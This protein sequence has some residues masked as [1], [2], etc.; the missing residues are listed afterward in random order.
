M[1]GDRWTFLVVRGEDDPVRQYS[2]SL[3]TIRLLGGVAALSVLA[4]VASTAILLSDAATRV[5][6]HSLQ[7]RNQVLEEELSGFQARIGDLE[8]SLDR[9][10]SNDAHFRSLAGLE[11]IDPEVLEAGVG[12]PGLGSP[13][14]S[15][16]WPT[17][18]ATTN[19]IF[20]TGYDLSALERRARLLSE[21][22]EEATDSVLAHRNLL[23]STPSL[24]PTQGWLS[25]RFSQSRMHPVHNRPLPHE[26]VD[27]SAP[28]GTPIMAAAKG[29]VVRSGWVVGYGLTVEIDHGYGFQ[30]LYGHASKLIVQVGDEV[31]RGDVI[32]Q[33]GSTGITTA[34]NLH[35]EVKVNGVAQDPS[36]FILPDY[37]RN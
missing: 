18:P 20:A 6:A 32:A 4:I 31:L 23:E 3:R 35:Y 12:G 2:L 24:L 33:V 30:T 22:L 37:V 27:I 15:P 25:S 14:N 13:E 5:Q 17:D 11:V 9:V 28:T 10:A 36:R 26:G 29:R 34:P 7:A 16:L 19:S 21:S 8:Q 1:A